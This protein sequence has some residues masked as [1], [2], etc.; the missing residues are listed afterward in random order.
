MKKKAGARAI[1]ALMVVMLMVGITTAFA[2][3]NAASNPSESAGTSFW[4]SIW[5]IL[6]DD[7]KEQLAN[8]AQEKL[9]EGLA[10][11][12]ITQEQYDKAIEAVDKGE[13]PFLGKFGRSGRSE[14]KE[15]RKAAMDEMKSKWNAL[16]DAQKAVIYDLN[17]Q[18]AVIDSQIID[19][20]VEFGII[21]AE[22]ADGMKSSLESQRSN[23]RTSGRM[24]MAGGR[25]M[26]GFR[27]P[28]GN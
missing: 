7:Q 11:G 18:K 20:Y 15:E 28:N 5:N 27:I 4:T 22:T 23:M 10:G 19:K 2:A 12:K 1:V 6:T 16:T 17:D 13:M 21:D 9:G 25:G 8:E 3:G 24:P 26:K 14:M